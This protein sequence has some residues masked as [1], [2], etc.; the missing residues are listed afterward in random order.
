MLVSE[1]NLFELGMR[2]IRCHLRPLD[3][4]SAGLP[5][6]F[7]FEG[8]HRVRVVTRDGEP[9]FSLP[10]VCDVLSIAN[11]PDVAAR[12]D[13]NERKTVDLI[14]G[15]GRKQPTNIVNESGLYVA[16]MTSRKPEARRFRKWVTGTML[17]TIGRTGSYVVGEE[18]L[19][20]G[21][22][23]ASELDAINDQV[24]TLLCR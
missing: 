5:A 22:L 9:W 19:Q 2:Q 21:D 3:A 11:S 24:I 6:V 16:I 13:A 14:D 10:D 15:M 4:P 12:L 8:K 23:S 1:S 17:P 7:T 20:Q 18:K